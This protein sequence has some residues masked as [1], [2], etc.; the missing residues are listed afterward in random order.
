MTDLLSHIKNE[1]PYMVELRRHFHKFPEPSLKEFKTAAKIEEELSAMDIPCKR[2]GETGVLGTIKGLAGGEGKIIMLRADI[3]ALCIQ[4]ENEAPYRS[5][6]PGI[7]HACGHDGHVAS[8]LG[9]AKVLQANRGKF[10][11]T[12]RL[13]FQQAEEI[14]DGA[15]HFIA[16]G[17]LEG[18]G[19]AFAV[20]MWPDLDTGK[21]G[22]VSGPVM[23]SA[24]YFRIKVKGKSA[25]VSTPHKGADALYAA[26]Q[27]VSALQG[28]VTRRTSPLSTVIIGVGTIHSGTA[29]NI[30]PEEAILEGTTRTLTAKL[31]E[32]VNNYVTELSAHTA[33]ACGTEREIEWRANTS[34]LV[35]DA[36]ACEEVAAIA[37]EISSAIAGSDGVDNHLPPSLG[38]DDFAEFLLTVPGVYV[39]VGCGFPGKPHIPLHNGRFDIDE[40]SL[41]YAGGMYACYASWYLGS[42]Q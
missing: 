1:K 4:E 6:N 8:L 24:D 2:V 10:A 3:D 41:V 26:C 38:G 31:R 40:D 20:H 5:E 29:Y 23:A 36:A 35:N 42:A 12:V 18:V 22:V 9:A 28:I 16:D 11:G 19:R 27:I 30:V 32:E 34:V 33:A 13:V 17:A 39:R 15:K 21:I 14:G 37:A 7:M 25:H